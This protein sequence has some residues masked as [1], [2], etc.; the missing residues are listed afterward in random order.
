M[1]TYRI[2]SPSRGHREDNAYKALLANDPDH[3]HRVTILNMMRSTQGVAK[4]SGDEIHF[5]RDVSMIQMG[6]GVS[7]IVQ[8]PPISYIFEDA[9]GLRQWICRV[10][11]VDPIARLAA[12]ARVGAVAAAI[13]RPSPDDLYILDL[14]ERATKVS[15]SY[16]HFILT[17]P[18]IMEAQLRCDVFMEGAAPGP[19]A[20]QVEYSPGKPV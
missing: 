2:C 1:I 13:L 7:R 20:V 12:L 6:D 10:H 9:A 16:R 8:P 5:V 15:A 18:Q 17:E 19:A 3:A 4:G 14:A 11:V